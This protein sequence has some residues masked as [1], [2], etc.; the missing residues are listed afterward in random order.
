MKTRL[1]HIAIIP[2]LFISG[3]SIEFPM[4]TQQTHTVSFV[5]GMS[6][7]TRTAV[8]EGAET[9]SYT[10][11]ADDA[12]RF[13]IFE[14]GVPATEINV[15]FS[16]DYKQATILASFPSSGAKSFTYTA[17]VNGASGNE[18]AVSATQKLPSDSYDPDSDI[19]VSKSVFSQNTLNSLELW[20]SRSV[21]VNKM[22]LHGLKAGETLSRI[23]I[24]SDMSLTGNDLEPIVLQPQAGV[25][26]A[27]DAAGNL[28]VR[29]ITMPV[30][31]ATLSIRVETDKNVYTKTFSDKISFK[32]NVFTRF[33]VGLAGCED[34]SYKYDI[35]DIATLKSKLTQDS[36]SF[37]IYLKNATVTGVNGNTAY[38]QDA[39]AAI[40]MYNCAS[41][42]AKGDSFTGEVKIQAQIYSSSKQPEITSF[43]ASKAV[44]TTGCAVP[45]RTVTIAELL[46]DLNGFD[47]MYVR[48]EGGVTSTSL[49]GKGG[50]TFTQSTSSLT[51]YSQNAGISATAGSTLNVCGYPCNY[52][53]RTPEVIIISPDDM[54][55]VSAG[56]DPVGGYIGDGNA[57]LGQQGWLELPAAVSTDALAGTSTSTFSDL[58]CRAHYAR[59]NGS[60]QRNYTMLYDPE[61]LTSYWVA[62]PL[63]SSHLGTGRDENWGYDPEVPSTKQTSVRSGY[64]MANFSTAYHSDNFYA[65][66]HQIPNADRNG[67]LEMMAQTFYSTNMTP[68]IQNGFN[69]GIWVNAENAVRSAVP[70]GDTLYVVTGAAFRKKGGSETIETRRNNN[71]GKLLPI[72]NYYWKVLLKVRRNGDQIIEAMAIGLWFEHKD[73]S[74]GDFTQYAVSVDQIEAWTGFDFFC[75]LPGDNSGGIE[76]AA[77]AND[78]WYTFKNY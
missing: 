48:V 78:K 13:H 23:T 71:D 42:L 19:L 12:S 8:T 10:W 26:I 38:I 21:A 44:K 24:D 40:Y 73:Y 61:M 75:N 59:M 63:C 25:A 34:P 16:G 52:G 49:S 29:F 62:Y 74:N 67:V 22:T 69:S 27:A 72:P 70:Y 15:S 6:P 4:L 43:D 57:A 46:A 28:S 5:A 54:T 17:F 37:T 51:L 30:T 33:D 39:T 47:A 3:C 31:D 20:F 56:S 65:R 64:G 45:C 9:A 60:S 41:G 66:G 50:T 1:L 58:F 55:V 36:Q 7:E 32:Q 77:E 53:G 14:N 18:A 11:S 35:R 68:Q 2:L 76:A